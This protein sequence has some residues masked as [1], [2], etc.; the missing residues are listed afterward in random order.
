MSF[1]TAQFHILSVEICKI[2]FLIDPHLSSFRT[3]FNI[4]VQFLLSNQMMLMCRCLQ[5]N[6]WSTMSQVPVLHEFHEFSTYMYCTRF[7]LQQQFMNF[8]TL[9][10]N[11]LEFQV[12]HET[13]VTVSFWGGCNGIFKISLSCLA[14]CSY[15]TASLYYTVAYLQL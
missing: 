9:T 15:E 2:I 7:S 5:Y 8:R 4:A 10:A 3:I 6:V 14:T 11:Y 1:V 12:L 13:P